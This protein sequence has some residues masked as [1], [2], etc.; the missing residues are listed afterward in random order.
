M[1]G[2]PA[3]TVSLALTSTL[4]TTPT[5]GTAS[6][7]WPER[8]STRPGATASQRLSAG[9]EAVAGASD[10][11]PGNP[12][13]ATIA[14]AAKAMPTR[15]KA[16]VRLDIS[17]HLPGPCHSLLKLAAAAQFF[18]DDQAILD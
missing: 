4:S 3:N 15:I 9:D 18:P 7:I 16:V 17:V 8:G 5:T 2:S 12:T 14:P 1:S 10:C 6:L 11:P 13:T